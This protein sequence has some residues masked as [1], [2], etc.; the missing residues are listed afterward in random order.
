MCS[1]QCLVWHS[2]PQSSLFHISYKKEVFR[3]WTTKDTCRLA[4]FFHFHEILADNFMFRPVV[5]QTVLTAILHSITVRAPLEARGC[6]LAIREEILESHSTVST[7][8]F[9]CLGQSFVWQTWLQYITLEHCIHFLRSCENF[10]QW[11]HL[12]RVTPEVYLLVWCNCSV[13]SIQVF[14]CSGQS[15]AWQ[16]RLQYWTFPHLV[17]CSGFCKESSCYFEV[18]IFSRSAYRLLG[19]QYSLF[20]AQVCTDSC[21]ISSVSF[22]IFYYSTSPEYTFHISWP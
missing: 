1:F 11:A 19:S 22:G 7:Q 15:L 4:H 13:V 5:L 14:L 16:S 18:R 17:H 21:A 2:F 3:S 9:L 8:I 20:C 6:F 10:L 12:G